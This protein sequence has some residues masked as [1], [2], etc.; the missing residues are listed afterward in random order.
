MTPEA[1]A[2]ASISEGEYKQFCEYFYRKTGI[3]FSAQKRYFV[4]KR[5]ADR[6][7]E[8]DHKSFGA[9]FRSLRL[10]PASPE[11]QALVDSMTV[12]ETYFYREIEQLDLLVEQVL[13]ELAVSG[14]PRDAVRIWSM[15]CSTGE[16]PYSLAIK[17]LEDWSQVDDF[18]IGLFGT[19]IDS[20]VI[21]KAQVGLFSDRSV[22]RLSVDLRQRYFSKEPQGW[23]IIEELRE[24]IDF[25]RVNAL[26][27]LAMSRFSN[28]DVIF[29]RNMLIYF[30]DISRRKCLDAFYDALRPGGF[31]FLGM[32]E[33]LGQTTSL[34]E[35]ERSQG[36]VVYRRP[37]KRR[38]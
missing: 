17:L 1:Q 29:C 13:P 31:L 15:P 33:S 20:K 27:R 16:E 23:R 24:S 26:D 9:W 14:G 5:I 3:R 6:I 34:F 38:T 18:D 19:D 25:R 8:G 12:N 36:T 30:D 28:F 32:S 35:T 4:D 11:L 37:Q 10:N 2:N 21:E 22:N 7:S